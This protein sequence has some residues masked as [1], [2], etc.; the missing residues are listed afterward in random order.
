MRDLAPP[1]NE[2]QWAALVAVSVKV[3]THFNNY[4]KIHRKFKGWMKTKEKEVG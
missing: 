3:S 1:N 2:P 4:H